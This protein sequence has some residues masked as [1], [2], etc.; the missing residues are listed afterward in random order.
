[1]TCFV[2]TLSF[3][4]AHCI[5]LSVLACRM[6]HTEKQRRTGMHPVCD[7]ILIAFV[8]DKIPCVASLPL[9]LSMAYVY[10]VVLVL[11]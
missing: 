4:P 6:T 9:S 11:S 2:G 1:M 10:S 3:L 7:M 8:L 5:C